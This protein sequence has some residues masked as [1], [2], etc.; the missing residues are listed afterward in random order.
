MSGYY[1]LLIVA[2]FCHIRNSVAIT[3]QI[4]ELDYKNDVEAAIHNANA[5]NVE[6]SPVTYQCVKLFKE[7]P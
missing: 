6:G 2:Q 3:S 5:L 1:K 4:V 7:A